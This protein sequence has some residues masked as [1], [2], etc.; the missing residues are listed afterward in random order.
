MTN[1]EVWRVT[2]P[3]RTAT[4]EAVRGQLNYYFMSNLKLFNQTITDVRTQN[5]LQGVLG[6]KKSEFV[7]N[8]T[9]LVANNAMLQECEPM[10]LMYSALKATALD[11]PLDQN[12][13][14][15]YVLP[16]RNTKAGRTE[17]QFQL[18]AKGI[19]QLAIRS[20]QFK[21]INVT[22]VREGEL[23]GIDRKTGYADVEWITDLKERESKRIIGYL[24]YF[25]LLNG[26]EKESYWSVEDLEKHGAKYS[27]TYRKGFGVW[28]DNFEAMAK[29][30]L[31]VTTLIPTMTGFKTMGQLEVGDTI[32]NG[33][34]EPTTV[35]AKSEVKHLP[36]YR[37]TFGDGDS[38]VCDHEHKWFVMPIGK[39]KVRD[40]GWTVVETKTLCDAMK[41]GCRFVAPKKVE[42]QFPE[43]ILPIDPYVLG[44]YL[45]KLS[46]KGTTMGLYNLDYDEI[47]KNLEEYYVI[48]NTGLV[49]YNTKYI[50]IYENKRT[51]VQFDD[52]I[53]QLGLDE[54]QY[55]PMIYKRSSIEQ[56]KALISGIMDG[57][58]KTAYNRC[59]FST[60]KIQVAQDVFEVLSS[61]GIKVKRFESIHNCFGEDTTFY[62][63]EW[64][65]RFN[66]FRVSRKAR[67]IEINDTETF[68]LI[69]K[70]EP[71]ESEPTQCIA[72]DSFGA[73]EENDLR[74]SYLYGRRFGVTH[75]TVLKLM[76]NK[77]DAPL[78]VQMQNALKYDQAV[79][80]EQ[81]NAKYIDNQKPSSID[82]ATEFLNAEVVEDEAPKKDENKENTNTNLFE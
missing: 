44:F 17:A 56:R 55:I 41:F 14:F 71:I 19:T 51:G 80:D 52:D 40:I 53:K 37:I 12:L 25:K 16:Y 74:K 43:N 11:L 15:A 48:Q 50:R 59:R 10:T 36:C 42:V 66:P 68:D 63:L 20:G 49:K 61:L 73:T 39:K 58:G 2:K 57:T 27:Q 13:G 72:V 33:L 18:G 77:G 65:P 29:K 81:G 21:T 32:Y 28:K 69:A 38:V 62:D 26:Y 9:A 82:Q 70:V 3:T 1:T 67:T 76:L 24:G 46:D 47:Y 45:S 35:I 23:K 8:L 5:Y 79:I 31:A 4:P 78:S 6:E 22:D 54:R 30:G 34:G 60:P 64:K 7:N 75:N